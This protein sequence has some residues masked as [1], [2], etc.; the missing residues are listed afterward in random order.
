MS[1]VPF[2]KYI[3]L[4][5]LVNSGGT[6]KNLFMVADFMVMSLSLH[7]QTLSVFNFL[8]QYIVNANTCEGN[9]TLPHNELPNF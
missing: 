1:Q 8:L 9:P 2:L 5:K 4:E 6:R 3:Q 7:Q